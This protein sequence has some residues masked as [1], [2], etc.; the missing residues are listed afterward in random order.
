[1]ATH[2]TTSDLSALR[3]REVVGRHYDFLWR[4]LRRL[5]VEAADVEDAAQ[6][7]LWV[8]H[9]KLNSVKPETER[10]FLFGTAMRIAAD[11]RKRRRRSPE[12]VDFDAIERATA[13]GDLE[14]TLDERRARLLLDRVLDE[15][16]DELRSVFVLAELEELT[17]ANVAE[18]LAVPPGT[19]ASRLRRARELFAQKAADLRQRIMTEVDR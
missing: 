3:M 2:P 19:V 12:V 13:P 11:A 18:V 4:S 17:M 5:G 1:M 16:P 8:L 15:L 10:A 6:K 14:R 7:V 9:R